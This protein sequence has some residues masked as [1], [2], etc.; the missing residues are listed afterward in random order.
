MKSFLKVAPELPPPPYSWLIT[1]D[2]IVGDTTNCADWGDNLLTAGDVG[3]SLHERIPA[4]NKRLI[5]ARTARCR[6]SVVFLLDI[7]YSP[8]H[9]LRISG[10]RKQSE[11]LNLHADPRPTMTRRNGHAATG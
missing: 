11:G 5:A 3:R 8:A 7:R 4:P 9:A 1:S 2:G 6:M 10:D